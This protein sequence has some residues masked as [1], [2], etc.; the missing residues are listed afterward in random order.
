MLL[1]LNNFVKKSTDDKIQCHGQIG[2]SETEHSV[3]PLRECGIDCQPTSDSC[4]RRRH[5]GA[6]LRHFYSLLL[7]ELRWTDIHG[8]CNAPSVYCRRR[9]RNVLVT[10]TVRPL[11]HKVKLAVAKPGGLQ[12]GVVARV[13]GQS[14]KRGPEAKPLVRGR[15]PL[16]LKSFEPSEDRGSW[17]ICHPVKY[18]VNCSNILSEKVFVSP[19]P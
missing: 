10:V 7:T 12:C 9:I 5:S 11:D 16:K 6:I 13:W 1:I 2:S 19:L 18:S 4:V 17:Q 14:P 15:S 3:S 8:L